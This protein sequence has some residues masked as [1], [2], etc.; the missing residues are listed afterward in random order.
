[1]E[2]PERH[3]RWEVATDQRPNT[4]KEDDGSD[5]DDDDDD[6]DDGDGDGDDDSQQ[7]TQRDD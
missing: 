1:M 7:T 5:D 3:G 6:D 4:S 2:R